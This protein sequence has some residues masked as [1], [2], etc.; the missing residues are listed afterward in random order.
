MSGWPPPGMG[1]ASMYLM[2]GL[3]KYDPQT[4]SDAQKAYEYS[5]WKP[6]KY[7]DPNI[8]KVPE[9]ELL[10]KGYELKDAE[11]E[12]RGD[13]LQNRLDLQESLRNATIDYS[14]VKDFWTAKKYPFE[15]DNI[16]TPKTPL[17]KMLPLVPP[18]NNVFEV[19]GPD[20]NVTSLIDE[21]DV[22]DDPDDPTDP[23]KPTITTG[24]TDSSYGVNRDKM[25]NIYHASMLGTDIGLLINNLTQQPPPR[26]DFSRTALSRV[27][28]DLTPY[29][30]QRSKF[31]E[32]AN[33]SFR[34]GRE[35]LGQAS[36]MMKMTQGLATK[37]QEA[38]RDVGSAERQ[39]IDK[40]R[41]MNIEISNKEQMINDQQKDK[42]MQVN[43]AL[44]AQFY[45][46]RG[47]SI[48]K[49]VG[50]IKQDLKNM[51]DYSIKKDYM[52]RSE[53]F[54]RDYAKAQNAINRAAV[55]TAWD[56]KEDPQYTSM[57]GDRQAEI[58][59]EVQIELNEKHAISMPDESKLA[60]Q[61]LAL[62]KQLGAYK[63]FQDNLGDEPSA[64]DYTITEKPILDDY[65]KEP[66]IADYDAGVDF[67]EPWKVTPEQVDEQIA[68][69]Q[70]FAEDQIEYNKDPDAYAQKKYDA[71]LVKYEAT[72][73]T[74]Y[75]DAMKA[76]DA[77][78][79]NIKAYE[80]SNEVVQADIDKKEAYIKDLE[81]ER[82]KRGYDRIPAEVRKELG[83]PDKGK[84]MKEIMELLQNSL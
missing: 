28:V 32:I 15:D 60:E 17:Q 76:Y 39:A 57:V 49:S 72:K 63:T 79:A 62:A 40:E 5:K 9:S 23:T 29:D 73:D 77:K 25:A 26:Q 33:R 66:E 3:E 65:E 53:K 82:K 47:E 50:A 8:N 2:Y 68:G 56:P 70:K 20:K 12:E 36:D 64:D 6:D 31:Q 18:S 80:S 37:G 81:I 59:N 16:T 24:T 44:M 52:D 71:D 38:L 30:L 14:P 7:K 11:Q 67:H 69:Q 48:S 4:R 10:R 35:S 42:E 78:V 21:D 41:M 84:M 46:D 75:D 58:L 54:S 45:R 22:I 34:K 55:L 27:D 13:Q 1:P 19:E 51:A 83:I 61:K 74:S 43:H